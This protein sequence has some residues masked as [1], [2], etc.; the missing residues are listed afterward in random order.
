MPEL[1]HRRRTLAQLTED[2][3]ALL[4]SYLYSTVWRTWDYLETTVSVRL[5]QDVDADPRAIVFRINSQ[6]YL[7]EVSYPPSQYDGLNIS[8]FLDG[9]AGVGW[10]PTNMTLTCTGTFMVEFFDIGGVKVEVLVPQSI[11]NPSMVANQYGIRRRTRWH[12]DIKL[13]TDLRIV[14]CWEQIAEKRM[15]ARDFVAAEKSGGL[16]E[17]QLED[18]L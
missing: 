15:Q 8:S 13:Y 6:G 14:D 7:R 17:I 3:N 16:R 4:R 10:H 9:T 12:G 2:V 18:D 11:V 1:D 5:P